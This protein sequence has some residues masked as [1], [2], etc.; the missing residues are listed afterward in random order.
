MEPQLCS[1]GSRG[2]DELVPG[3]VIHIWIQLRGSP[4]CIPKVLLVVLL[5]LGTKLEAIPDLARVLCAQ[6][7]QVPA[8]S[9]A[10][11]TTLAGSNQQVGSRD[12][13]AGTYSTPRTV[14]P[15]GHY[16]TPLLFSSVLL[17]KKIGF[18]TSQEYFILC[19]SLK[20]NLLKHNQ[21]CETLKNGVKILCTTSDLKNCI[22]MCNM[23]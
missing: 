2:R 7:L 20:V 18:M 4:F 19:D 12:L 1:L 23:K 9:P 5:V 11:L 8:H 3:Y 6:G 13:S 17:N 10:E 15:Q 22:Y 16:V 14:S 21:K